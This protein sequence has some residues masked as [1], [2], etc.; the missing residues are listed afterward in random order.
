MA[1]R[2]RENNYGKQRVRLLQLAREKDRHAIKELNFG[3]RLEGDFEIAHTQ[4]D[5]RKILPTDT[6]KNT[7][8][9]LARKNPIETAEQFCLQLMEHF[10]AGNPQVSGVRIEAA[11]TLWARLP[12]GGKSHPYTF[13][14]SA[15]E[16]R[17]VVAS[18][19]L[20][21]A[22]APAVITVSVANAKTHLT[23]TTRA[24]AV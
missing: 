13:T 20:H 10:L 16:Q 19:R 21:P 8:Y 14:R 18:E 7:V 12:F 23:I 24:K 11:E 6:M 2:L 3:I 22:E 9:A 4:G 1:I 15:V 5:N 17:T